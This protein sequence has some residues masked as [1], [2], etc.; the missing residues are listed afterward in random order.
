ME[1]EMCLHRAHF[2]TCSS[3]SPAAQPWPLHPLSPIPPLALGAGAREPSNPSPEGNPSE[4]AELP[5]LQNLHFHP[6]SS[7]VSSWTLT[8]P[9][10]H[11]RLWGSLWRSPDQLISVQSPPPQQKSLPVVPALSCPWAAPTE[12][13]STQPAGTAVSQTTIP[14]GKGQFGHVTDCE[15]IWSQHIHV[16]GKGDLVGHPGR[17]GWGPR[18]GG[19]RRRLR[20][21]KDPWF[22]G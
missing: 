2:Q 4:P 1:T 6:L 18:L 14:Q 21:A 20:C 8:P 9:S 15:R 19:L 22:S 16:T 11:C 5:W 10:F 13:F 12:M 17:A 7:S 3:C